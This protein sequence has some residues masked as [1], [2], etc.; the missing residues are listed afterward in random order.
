MRRR[1][2]SL[3][4][5]GSILG[6]CRAHRRVE[7][8][9]GAGLRYLAATLNL[10][11][12]SPGHHWVRQDSAESSLVHRAWVVAVD[13]VGHL[14]DD[15]GM[16]IASHVALSLLMTIFPFIIFV[17]ALAGFLGD[18]ALAQ[19]VANIIFEIWPEQVA[20]PIAAQVH[21]VLT[22]ATPS[23]LTV[24]A[25]VAIFLASNGIEAVRTALNRAYRCSE[26]RSVFFRRG[27]SLVFVVIGAVASLIIAF[28]GV[29]GPTA[30][31]YLAKH[32][33]ELLPYEEIYSVLR[34]VVT[35]ALMVVVLVAAHLWLPQSR[36]PASQ[37][38]PGLVAT[39]AL[40]FVAGKVFAF[41]LGKFANYAATYAGL[42]SVVTAIFF[43]YLIALIMILG[44]ELNAALR[45]LRDGR[46][47]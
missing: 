12:K 41:Y 20:G 4:N 39:L 40:W 7:A 25:V 47:R 24:S 23:L 43:L 14:I 32:F 1:S 44:A 5:G 33:P 45:R 27:Q 2:V 19:Q 46:L 21:D 16:A 22:G 31:A 30:F 28:L 11:R 3:P 37:L 15:D 13:A 10:S 8:L 17:A 35:A 29:L 18:L 9:N 6:R 34:A 36:P 26:T 42:A 38:W